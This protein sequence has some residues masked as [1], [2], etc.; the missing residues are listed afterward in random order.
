MKKALLLVVVLVLNIAPD[1][2]RADD[3]KIIAINTGNT[4]LVHD[5]L[6]KPGR[7]GDFR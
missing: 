6:W 1:F 4:L 2:A 5:R 3:K 7:N